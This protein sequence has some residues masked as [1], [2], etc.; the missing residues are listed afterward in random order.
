MRS[1]QCLQAQRVDNGPY[2]IIPVQDEHIDSIRLWRNAQ[3]DILRQSSVISSQQQ[4][5]YFETKVWPEMDVLQ[6]SNILMAF[7]LND[8][9]IGYGGLVHISW[10]HLRAEVSFLV[11]PNRA[12]KATIYASDQINFLSLMKMLAF[13]QLG[14]HRIFTESYDIRPQH[15][16]N[17]E[18]AGFIREGVMRAHVHINGRPVD[19]IIHGCL[20]TYEK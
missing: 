5:S 16:V 13:D 17:I 12:K 2:S 1:Y 6:P 19:S 4:Q 7:L 15:L 14:F 10:E 18:T 20:R 11:E 8:E 3:M 9:L